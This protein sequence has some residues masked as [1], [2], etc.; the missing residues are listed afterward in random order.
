M[1]EGAAGTPRGFA[2]PLPAAK[3]ES[4]AAE[5]QAGACPLCRNHCP[6]S[7]PGC[8]R[9]AAYAAGNLEDAGE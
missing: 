6:L 4:A 1:A 8:R 3:V 2:A 9:G 7:A 5:P